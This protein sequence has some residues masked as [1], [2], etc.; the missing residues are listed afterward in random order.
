MNIKKYIMNISLMVIVSILFTQNLDLFTQKITLENSLRDKIYSELERV[1]N[2]NKNR[3]VVVVNLELGKYGDLIS[4]NKNDNK[5]NQNSRGMEYLPGVPLS[6]SKGISKNNSTQRRIGANDYIISEIDISIYIEQSLAT[7][8]NEKMI[9]SLVKGIIPQTSNCD[10]CIT[11]ETMN[12]QTQNSEDTEL[13][14][15]RKELEA[16]KES[17]RKR[18]LTEL[19]VQLADLQA[20]LEDSENERMTWEDY[21]RRRDSIKVAHWEEAKA[22]EEIV[23]KEQLQTV[24]NKLDTAIN[25]RIESETQTKN[26]LIDIIG[27][28]SNDPLS[29]QGR[30]SGGTSPFIYLAIFLIIIIVIAFLFILIN[31]K[32]VVYLKPKGDSPNNDNA[33][34]SPPADNNNDTAATQNQNVDDNS[35][36]LHQPTN[37]TAMIDDSVVQSEL[38]ALRQSSIAMSASQ[39]EGA[40]QI[41]K[42]WIDDGM[43]TDSSEESDNN[44]GGE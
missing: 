42:D 2:K 17:E 19:N 37:T 24:Q 16:F 38:K 1:L 40:T 43:P 44:E 30:R 9:E 32:S 33:S 26:D 6:G 13:Q 11:I 31:K 23:L 27:G 36:N 10:D 20:R 15:L 18:Q 35:S 34:S 7:G 4:Q 28:R 29:M 21:E 25:R 22:Q 39:K 8:S 3:F 12:F 14:K 5:G 41:V